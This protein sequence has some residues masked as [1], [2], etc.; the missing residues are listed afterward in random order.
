[1]LGLGLMAKKGL[2]AYYSDYAA[3]QRTA[4]LF[5]NALKSDQYKSERRILTVMAF[6][7]KTVVGRKLFSLFLQLRRVIRKSDK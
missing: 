3:F 5:K 1:M 6:M 4:L 7:S 2:D